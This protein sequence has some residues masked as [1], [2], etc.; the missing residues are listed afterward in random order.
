M[1]LRFHQISSYLPEQVLANKF[2]ARTV[3]AKTSYLAEQFLQVSSYLPDLLLQRRNMTIEY[4]VIYS[5][6]EEPGASQYT[7]NA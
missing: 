3:L 7:L 2:F 4:S 5:I 6:K 1:R